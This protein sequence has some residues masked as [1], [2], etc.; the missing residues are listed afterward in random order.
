MREYIAQSILL[1][2]R[3]MPLLLIQAGLYISFGLLVIPFFLIFI[4]LAAPTA[5]LGTIVFPAL[6]LLAM[7]LFWQI[8]RWVRRHLLFRFRAAHIALLTEILRTGK[9][10]SGNDQF[11]QGKEAVARRFGAYPR[12]MDFQRKFE[13]IVRAIRRRALLRHPVAM[14]FLFRNALV[15]QMILAY[16]FYRDD[17]DP[18]DAVR[19][20]L[21]LFAGSAGPFFGR[22]ASILMFHDAVYALLLLILSLPIYFLFQAIG[23]PF[24]AGF[25]L[26]AILALMTRQAFVDPLILTTLIVAFIRESAG[27]TP[28]PVWEE[29]LESFFRN[30]RTEA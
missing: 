18:R 29:K 24:I 19:E 8:S 12:F 6:L 11:H 1:I 15:A 2:S 28:D 3:T 16:P 4:R 20:G 13:R 5:R 9:R 25:V 10:P 14:I 17:L 7:L 27:K 23:I 26:A 22:T 30:F 21:V